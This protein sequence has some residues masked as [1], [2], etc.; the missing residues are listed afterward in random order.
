MRTR[1]HP[2]AYLF[3]AVV[4]AAVLH[5]PPAAAG[6]FEPLTAQA[7]GMGAF[8]GVAYY[9]EEEEGLR[10]V[11]TVAAGDASFRVISTLA[12][13]QA[14]TLAVPQ[15]VDQ[16]E[17]VINFRRV[18]DRLHMSTPAAIVAHPRDAVRSFRP[19]LMLD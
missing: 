10:L 16:S 18:G 2:S 8:Q 7:L 9:T 5:A 14:V 4:A 1:M 6:E 13:N 11:A 19:A 12:E 15:T 17:Q 3:P